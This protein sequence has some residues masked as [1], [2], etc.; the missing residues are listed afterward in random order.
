MRP[1]I[2]LLL[3]GHFIHQY[4]SQ[5]DCDKGPIIVTYCSISL[6]NWNTAIF[7]NVEKTQR[8]DIHVVQRNKIF[9]TPEKLIIL[10]KSLNKYR[11]FL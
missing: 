2:Q 9:Y 8:T 5:D 6:K 7:R 11:N 3:C 4:V 10:K 1:N